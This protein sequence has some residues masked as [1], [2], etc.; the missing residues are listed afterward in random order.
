MSKITKE[1]KERA[2]IEKVYVKN[3]IKNK[4]ASKM[5]KE[6][7][8]RAKI[9]ELKRNG[10]LSEYSSKLAFGKII[11][12]FFSFVRESLMFIALFLFVLCAI[13]WIVLIVYLAATNSFAAAWATR[14][15]TI[16]GICSGVVLVLYLIGTTIFA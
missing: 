13:G 6:D 12:R 16:Y 5:T 8:E 15:M 7:K 3:L 1:D 2:K 9:E 14:T 11:G 4:K 10:E